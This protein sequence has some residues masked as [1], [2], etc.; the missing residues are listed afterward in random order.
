MVK[1]EIKYIGIICVESPDVRFEDIIYISTN[2]KEF[3][4]PIDRIFYDICEDIQVISIVPS[5]L[6][7]VAAKIVEQNIILTSDSDSYTSYTIVLSGIRKGF[8][9]KCY[10]FKTRE[11]MIK[12]NMFWKKAYDIS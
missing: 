7:R 2:K 11:E 4:V 8:K 12:N 5:R 3:T 1:N 6:V 10:S 9:N